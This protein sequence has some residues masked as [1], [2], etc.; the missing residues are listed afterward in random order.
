MNKINKKVL[1]IG[2][3][4]DIYSKQIISILRKRFKFL[5]IFLC[6]NKKCKPNKKILNWKGDIIFSFRS[7]FIL[8]QNFINKAKVCAIN[9]HPGP[10]SYRGIGCVNFALLNNEK[11]Y[12]CTAHLIDK[13]ID[14]GKILN[15]KIFKI[16]KNSS[17]DQVLQKTY[18]IQVK[19]ANNIVEKL[20]KK[21][22]M[23]KELFKNKKWSKKLYTRKELDD[24][25]KID[26]NINKFE[27]QKKIRAIKIKKFK[28]FISLFGYKF[29]LK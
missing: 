18:K 1:F 13:K 4:N 21:D 11:N 26:V 20:I 27:L 19:Q 24:L 8:N 5:E 16:S 17:V 6:K 28:P 29:I 7:F 9:F 25:Y 22:F 3:S 23:I 10:P 2:K 15:Y 14:S 12:G